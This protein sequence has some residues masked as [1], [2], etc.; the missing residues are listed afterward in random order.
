MIAQIVITTAELAIPTETRNNKA[1]G[2][3]ETQIQSPTY[4]FY[5]LH[6]LNHYVL[7]HLKDKLSF[8]LFF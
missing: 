5:A 8:H 4:F 1:K 3:T 6:S 7:F 2:E